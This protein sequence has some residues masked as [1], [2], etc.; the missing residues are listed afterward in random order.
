MA[1]ANVEFD[2]RLAT[3]QFSKQ[4]DDV[5]RSVRDFHSDFRNNSTVSQRA[6]GSFIGNLAASATMAAFRALG[7]GFQSI[8][9][10]SGAMV[11][12]A[13][14]QETLNRR[15]QFT[16]G[17]SADSLND[18]AD[19][20]QNVSRFANE[21]VQGAL[22]DIGNR[23]SLMNDEIEDATRLAIDLAEAFDMSLNE[24]VQLVSRGVEG[25]NT[26]FRRLGIEIDL[27]SDST[28]NLAIIQERLSSVNGAAED[29]V[30]SF[31]GSLA[32]LNNAYEDFLKEIG[33]AVLEIP[34]LGIILNEVTNAVQ[35]L[36]QWVQDNRETVVSW[37]NN[38]I[39]QA[40]EALKS[41]VSFINP[42]V[43]G[44]SV[45]THSFMSL[46]H[47]IMTIVNVWRTGLQTIVV[48]TTGFVSGIADLLTNLVRYTIGIFDKELVRVFE[49][50][51]DSLRVPFESSIDVLD[52]FAKATAES[53]SS[54]GNSA[55]SAYD[56]FNQ[57]LIP[58]STIDT[59]SDRVEQ[60]KQKIIEANE[61]AASVGEVAEG[62]SSNEREDRI[63]Q[64]RQQEQEEADRERLRLRTQHLKEMERVN[65][66]SLELQALAEEEHQIRLRRIVE[67]N[68]LLDLERMREI[69]ARRVELRKEFSDAEIEEKIAFREEE[70]AE[71]E[72]ANEKKLAEEELRVERE[73][74]LRRNEIEEQESLNELR[75][76][77]EEEDQKRRAEQSDSFWGTMRQQYGDYTRWENQTNAQR[78]A[79]LRGTMGDIADLTASS[80]QALF[81]LGQSAAITQATMDGAQAVTRA[82]ASAPPP[83]NFALAAAVGIRAA[84]QINMIKNQKRP[85][86]RSM[87]FAQGG[88]V[89]GN[90]FTGD[91]IQA[92]L[93][94]GEMVLNKR[95]QA[96]LFQQ[97]NGQN[98]GN[99]AIAERLDRLE[100]AILERPVVLVA[101]DKEIARST[102]RGVQQGIQIGRSR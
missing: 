34:A 85:E 55:E 63:N 11:N 21:Q 62:K 89:P 59:L 58:Q 27:T 7:R 80:N 94:S 53:F 43:K 60:I 10:Q 67:N 61:A 56:A 79:N 26:A 15:M 49:T 25:Q 9:S 38:G 95:Q 51:A 3:Q 8:I 77:N 93:N 72:D 97:A 74:S 20:M 32:K 68:D 101:N 14:E 48:A 90:S 54:A 29:R 4:I 22:L 69:E 45:L 78:A 82:L 35:Y 57:D 99:S 30:N 13:V 87:A 19:S 23:T 46:Y 76:K 6:W 92:R 36:D 2:L 52:D 86:G 66:Q 96:S 83:F 47:A 40:M 84:A 100:K 12:M 41:F 24:A 33:T 18:F 71:I 91:N 5:Q 28:Q 75:R 81:R 37:V 88:I 44:L 17:Q 70:I 50:F 16:F 73:I 98:A 64:R 42:T 39:V 31:E 65:A 102:S 1:G